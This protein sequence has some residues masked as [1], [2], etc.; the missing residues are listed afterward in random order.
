MRITFILLLLLYCDA[1]SDNYTNHFNEAGKQ[2][3]INPAILNA[4]AKTE[5]NKN[6]N[7][8]NCANRNGSC[9]YGL[10][11][12]NSIHLPLLQKYGVYKEDLFEPR[13]NIFIGAWVL[14]KC[15][16]RHGTNYKA[17]NCY[18]GKIKGN[19]YYARVL[20][21]FKKTPVLSSQDSFPNIA[22]VQKKGETQALNDNS[23]KNEKFKILLIGDSLAA[24]LET[25]FRSLLEQYDVEVISMCK[26]KSD[27]LYWANDNLSSLIKKHEPNFVFVALGNNDF[28]NPNMESTQRVANELKESNIGFRW[29][30]PVNK[31]A[32][33]FNQIVSEYIGKENIIVANENIQLNDTKSLPTVLGFKQWSLMVLHNVFST[34]V[35]DNSI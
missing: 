17:L 31:D 3:G 23:Q 24:G 34:T 25:E 15:I 4:V 30:A 19:N 35:K 10:M 9:D 26:E 2:Y 20:S 13:T 33:T 18:N 21:N 22:N 27:T 12:I 29:I 14:K 16:M 28:V 8:V 7:A 6:P 5:S 32:S 11:Q 1:F